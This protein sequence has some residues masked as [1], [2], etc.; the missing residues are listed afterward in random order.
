MA[1]TVDVVDDSPPLG[2]LEAARA[3]AAVGEAVADAGTA[4]AP[5]SS[6]LPP[7]PSSLSSDHPPPPPPVATTTAAAGIGCCCC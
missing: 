1:A 3:L 2:T 4:G 7:K 6:L 5:S